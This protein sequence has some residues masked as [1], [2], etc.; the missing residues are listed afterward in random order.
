MIDDKVLED[1]VKSL[2]TMPLHLG[3]SVLSNSKRIMN[4]F[5][6]VIDGFYINDLYYEDFDSMYIENKYWDNLDKA[7]LI[8]KYLL[9]GK[10]DY[11][12]SGIFY[13]L[14]IAPKIKYCLTVNKFGVID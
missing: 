10:N 4:N 5:I 12:D 6:H 1:E 2:K 3:A 7:D 8:G 11:K 9:Q 14:F 13:G